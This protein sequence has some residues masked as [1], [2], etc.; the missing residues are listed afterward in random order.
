MCD[1]ENE[2]VDPPDYIECKRWLY[3]SEQESLW[4]EDEDLLKNWYAGRYN[5]EDLATD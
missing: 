4:L 3:D 1:E 5:E 2:Q